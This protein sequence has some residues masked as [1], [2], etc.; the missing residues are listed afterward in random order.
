MPATKPATTPQLPLPPNGKWQGVAAILGSRLT[1]CAAGKYMHAYVP[2][3]VPKVDG[4]KNAP[5]P[6]SYLR[7]RLSA[8]LLML[9]INSSQG[10][11]NRLA[12]HSF[13]Q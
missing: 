3:K 4:C 9:Y 5:A 8:Q 7:G 6:A 12:S 11:C 10:H 13:R 1:Q 2:N